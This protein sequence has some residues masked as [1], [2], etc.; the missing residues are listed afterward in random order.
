MFL[1]KKK[2][3]GLVYL[4]PCVGIRYFQGH[5]FISCFY[6]LLTYIHT[7]ICKYLM[8]CVG[9]CFNDDFVC[10]L[11]NGEYIYIYNDCRVCVFV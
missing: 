2:I 8:M 9:V 6:L 11:F 3:G 5:Y 1:L 4:Y 10:V 7:Y